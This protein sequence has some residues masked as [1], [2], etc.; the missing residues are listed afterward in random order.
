MKLSDGLN[1]IS[2]KTITVTHPTQWADLG[3]GT[4]F[5]TQ[6]LS[7]LLANGSTIYAIDTVVSALRKV[8]VADGITL[9]TFPLDFINN[10][11][12]FA[13]LDGIMMA[14]ALHYVKDKDRF[15]EKMKQHLSADGQLLIVEYDLTDANPWVPYPISFS[16]LQQLCLQ[17]SFLSIKKIGEMPSAFRRANL[18][19]AVT[20]M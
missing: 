13:A 9:K 16:A 6:V 14:N 20:T 10:V 3:C 17:H 15:I 11:W 12:P 4:G 19:S 1:L 8:K 18:Y 7:T 5:F 2:H